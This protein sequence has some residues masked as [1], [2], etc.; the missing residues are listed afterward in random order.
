MGGEEWSPNVMPF[1]R[2]SPKLCSHSTPNSSR[3]RQNRNC[4]QPSCGMIAICWWRI[5]EGESPRNSEDLDPGRD[6]RNRTDKLLA[7]RCIVF[8]GAISLQ[9]TIDCFYVLI[10]TELVVD[11]QC[12]SLM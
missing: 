11:R 5:R 2:R 8:I 10:A 7:Y 6:T 1:V 9:L 3:R 12:C 4:A